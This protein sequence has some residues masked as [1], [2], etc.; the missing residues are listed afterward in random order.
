MPS[1]IGQSSVPSGPLNLHHST[2]ISHVPTTWWAVLDAGDTERIR[3]TPPL[4]RVDVLLGKQEKV[5]MI[6]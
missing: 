3:Q 6:R 5:F 2:N 1:G 4:H